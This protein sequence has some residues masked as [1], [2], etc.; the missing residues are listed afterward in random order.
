MENKTVFEIL[1]DRQNLKWPWAFEH[2]LITL[3]KIIETK[4]GIFYF[5]K[6]YIR[7]QFSFEIAKIWNKIRFFVVVES[8][9]KN[10][11]IF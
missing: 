2:I 4:K 11:F 8:E 9:L 5:N 1:V 6:K 7:P 3:Y 10:F